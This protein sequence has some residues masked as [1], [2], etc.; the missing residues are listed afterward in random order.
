MG[1]NENTFSVNTDKN[2]TKLLSVFSKNSIIFKLIL[3]ILIGTLVLS[4][5]IIIY[6][7]IQIFSSEKQKAIQLLQSNADNISNTIN[8]RISLVNQAVEV[9][10]TSFEAAKNPMYPINMNR[11]EGF[12]LLAATIEKSN[13]SLNAYTLW[14]PNAFDSADQKFMGMEPYDETGRFNAHAFKTKDNNILFETLID[15]TTPGLNDWYITPLQSKKNTVTDPYFYTF[16]G[17]KMQIVSIVHP[18][19]INNTVYGVCGMD[20]SIDFIKEI[21]NSGI[22][23]N[24]VS[25]VLLSSNDVI[26]YDNFI[27][28]NLGKSLAEVKTSADSL[29]IYNSHNSNNEF[30]DTLGNYVFNKSIKIANT[31]HVWTI[32][33]QYP[34]KIVLANARNRVFN[35]ILIN[36]LLV[37]AV[38]LLSFYRIYKLLNPLNVLKNHTQKMVNGNLDQLPI[39]LRTDE[40]GELNN[41]FSA[42]SKQL[43]SM[44]V[45]INSGSENIVRASKE[46]SN[47]AQVLASGANE[48]AAASEQVSSAIEEMTATIQQNNNNAQ[49]TEKIARKVSMSI[50]IVRKAVDQTTAMMKTIANKILIINEIAGRTDL[51][52]INAA[53]EAARAGEYGRGFA[54]VAN[55]IRKLAEKSQ[56]AAKE[57]DELSG[58]G[59]TAASRSSALLNNLIPDVD[60]TAS[61]VQ[62]ISASSNEQNSNAIQVNNAIQQLNKVTQH[63]AASAEEMATSTEQTEQQA[64]SLKELVGFFKVNTAT[65][66]QINSDFENLYVLKKQELN[67]ANQ[68]INPENNTVS[69]IKEPIVKKTD[70]DKGF[71]LDLDNYDNNYEKY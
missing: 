43:S 66:Q 28:A 27:P 51:L 54:V 48:Q 39:T 34:K 15:Y 22:D 42:M 59:V 8:N 57:I 1:A 55:E 13:I 11:Q 26:V 71:N 5:T 52:A 44:V 29:A 14:E 60:K 7:S 20:M 2:K 63:N 49:E 6:G 12:N 64:E 40:I 69:E 50:Q 56:E 10:T 61:L 53:I 35:L 31:D 3:L 21:I 18:I 9:L 30:A 24:D 23:T 46:L 32:S 37:I 41:S 33:M 16:N 67:K 38:L 4:L 25:I 70:S 65:N 45:Q 58:S 36:I 62:E 17:V 47:A 19:Y 68:I